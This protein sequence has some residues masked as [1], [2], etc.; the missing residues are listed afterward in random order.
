MV[1]L[2]QNNPDCTSAAGLPVSMDVDGNIDVKEIHNRK[3]NFRS[4]YVPGHILSLQSLQGNE[5]F[6]SAPGQIF[7]F[8]REELIKLGGYHRAY[9]QSQLYGIVPFGV[10]GY[11]ETAF[12]YWRRHEGQLNLKLSWEGW[13]TTKEI[14]S[15][16][17]DFDLKNRWSVYGNDVSN[18]IVDNIT[19][20]QAE[21]AAAWFSINI[22]YFNMR[23]AYRIARDIWF[24]PK[25][26]LYIPKNIFV[27]QRFRTALYLLSKPI[28]KPVIYYIDNKYPNLK[29]KYTILNKILLRINTN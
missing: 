24:N 25:F 5:A 11:D 7:S 6:F 12:F 1:E 29:F 18:Y 19:Q 8:K 9:E 2:F 17:N 14:Y 20:Q 27:F 26:W 13:I 4:K 16:I 15:M 28:L 10:T 23:A 22:Y 3:T 21:S